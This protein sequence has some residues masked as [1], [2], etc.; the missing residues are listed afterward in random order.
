[1]C[2]RTSELGHHALPHVCAHVRTSVRTHVRTHVRAYTH[3]CAPVYDASSL[4][5]FFLRHPHRPVVSSVYPV[6]VDGIFNQPFG[7]RRRRVGG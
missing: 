7:A 6:H 3:V 1:M 4:L 2:G 5:F